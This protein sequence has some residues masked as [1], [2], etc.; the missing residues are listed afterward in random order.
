[1]LNVITSDWNYTPPSVVS[2]P[3]FCEM[4][5]AGPTGIHLLFAWPVKWTATFWS[6]IISAIWRD[7]WCQNRESRSSDDFTFFSFNSFCKLI[8]KNLSLRWARPLALGVKNSI[9]KTITC[10]P[11]AVQGTCFL[12]VTLVTLWWCCVQWQT[13]LS[14]GEA[15]CCITAHTSGNQTPRVQQSYKVSDCRFQIKSKETINTP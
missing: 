15:H 6:S 13:L 9:R 7:D 5:Q 11:R 3:T 8:I 2:D 4:L 12:Q 14:A 1:M 10:N